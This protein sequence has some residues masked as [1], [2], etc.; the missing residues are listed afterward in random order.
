M[1]RQVLVNQLWQGLSQTNAG[2]KQKKSML[3]T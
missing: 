1:E 3:Q 2:I